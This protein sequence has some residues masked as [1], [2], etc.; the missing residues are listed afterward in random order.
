MIKN[1][2][3][4]TGLVKRDRYGSWSDCSPGL[5]VDF[6]KVETVF[7]KYVGKNIKITVEILEEAL[8]ED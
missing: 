4:I 5:Y 7:E 6:D 3:T 2:E 8:E 1:T